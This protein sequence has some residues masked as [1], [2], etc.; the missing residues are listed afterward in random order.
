MAAEVHSCVVGHNQKELCGKGGSFRSFL[1]S[2]SFLAEQNRVG[3]Q[4]E[5]F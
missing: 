3:E 4:V 5:E 2:P 1:C